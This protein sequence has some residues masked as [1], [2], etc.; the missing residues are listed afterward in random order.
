MGVGDQCHGPAPF[1]PGRPGTHCTGGPIEVDP[2]PKPILKTRCHCRHVAERRQLFGPNKLHT[3][4]S[5]IIQ[6]SVRKRVPATQPVKDLPAICFSTENRVKITLTWEQ[7]NRKRWIQTQA[8]Y[9]FRE[10]QILRDVPSLYWQDTAARH[11]ARVTLL[12]ED[13][14]HRT[15]QMISDIPKITSAHNKHNASWR[16]NCPTPRDLLQHHTNGE[17]LFFQKS[18]SHLKSQAPAGWHE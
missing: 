13:S 15:D 8:I 12:H 6:P 4:P 9:D 16:Q 14:D 3:I 5:T 2:R 11:D 1:P 18:K 7:L 10:L 17:Q